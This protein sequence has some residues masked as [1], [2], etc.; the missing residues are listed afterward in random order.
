MTSC[1]LPLLQVVVLSLAFSSP[2]LALPLPPP[3]F[4]FSTLH[5]RLPEAL[6]TCSPQLPRVHRQASPQVPSL[7][8]LQG[9]FCLKILIWSIC[10]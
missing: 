9:Q 10:F 2:G 8:I 1:C 3:S 6:T 4:P 7:G 5:T